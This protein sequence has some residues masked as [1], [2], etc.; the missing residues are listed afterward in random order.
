MSCAQKTD[1]RPEQGMIGYW[2]GESEKDG[3]KQKWFIHRSDYGTFSIHFKFYSK[4]F[5]VKWYKEYGT[6][7]ITNGIYSTAT[8]KLEDENGF[9]YPDS[10]DKIYHGQY[11][12]LELTKDVFRYKEIKSN[13]IYQVKRVQQD[14]EF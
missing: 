1:V 10:P 3:R 13:E 14:F 11:Q 9:F 12:L 5:L 6:W 7:R 2:Y 8:T 4:D